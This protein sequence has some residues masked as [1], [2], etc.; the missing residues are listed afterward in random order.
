MSRPLLSD[1][2]KLITA[3]YPAFT[4]EIA[5]MAEVVN[6]HV[7]ACRQKGFSG[8]NSTSMEDCC[9]LYLL[10]RQF[11]RRMAFELGTFIGTTAIAMNEALKRSG[12][13]L[14]TCDPQNCRTIPETAG[15]RFINAVGTVALRALRE[16]GS[17]VDFAFIDW[18]PDQ[19]TFDL[20]SQVST[21]DLIIAVHDYIPQMKG[22][23]LVDALQERPAGRWFFPDSE[24]VTF[25][26]GAR[27]NA[28]TAFFI[29]NELLDRLFAVS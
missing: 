22:K 10:I 11:R 15:I 8:E 19:D 9:L 14:T 23:L 6:A 27:I 18:L 29:P 4:S 13:T 5:A 24:P 16:E 28:C 21:R 26:D 12:A 2:Q 7:T 1:T 3:I 20:L 25:P 17:C